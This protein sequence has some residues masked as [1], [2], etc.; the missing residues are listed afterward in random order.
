MGCDPDGVAGASLIRDCTATDCPLHALRFGKYPKNKA[1][2]LR[3]RERCN[4]LKHVEVG[5][6]E[7]SAINSEYEV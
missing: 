3:D 6:E 1:A 2:V 7:E 4:R 5:S